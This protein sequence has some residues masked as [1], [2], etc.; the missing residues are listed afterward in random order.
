MINKLESG[1]V[2]LV[3]NLFSSIQLSTT[4]KNKY[5][6]MQSL[7]TIGRNFNGKMIGRWEANIPRK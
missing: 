7:Y 3:L 6:Q 4:W 5:C 2:I 1:T